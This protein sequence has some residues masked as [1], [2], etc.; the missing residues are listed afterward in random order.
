MAGPL[1]YD[2]VKET[3]VTAGTGTV[4]LAG[5]ATGF[6]SFSVV[7]NGNS[8]YYCIEAGAEWEVGIGTYTS[9]G[10]TLSR[11]TV[12][13]SSNAGSLV[14]FSSAV[15]SVFLTMPAQRVSGLVAMSSGVEDSRP[16]GVE[17]MLY[18]ATD[19]SFGFLYFGG[20]W[21]VLNVG[22]D[23][24]TFG[25]FSDSNYLTGGV[26]ATRGPLFA[27]PYTL[28]MGFYVESLPG[29]N[30]HIAIAHSDNGLGSG[31]YL[32]ISTVNANKFGMPLKGVNSDAVNQF[33]AMPALT[34][35]PHA[36]A[37]K[38]NG[39]NLSYSFDGAAVTNIA[40]TGTFVPADA[41]DT[42]MLGRWVATTLP[43]D[44]L[45]IA[46]AR[47]FASAVSDANLQ[48]LSGSPSTYVPPS[49]LPVVTA[50]DWQARHYQ[51]S[52][53]SHVLFG[54]ASPPALTLTGTIVKTGR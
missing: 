5:A 29:T 33:S 45:S 4:T 51:A 27:N 19:T 11:D 47:G 44:F 17:G 40:T 13:A 37:V 32:G 50:W 39:S 10:T 26:G 28:A 34:V 23:K 15:K 2:R 18:L 49:I 30:N 38:Y 53:P 41:G 36:I 48:T 20:A 6:R 22:P 25:P 16:A 21:T 46:W 14:A 52:N 35:G 8:C 3:T 54:S 24:A 12:L 31:W 1:F 9:S 42:F 43:G 7:G